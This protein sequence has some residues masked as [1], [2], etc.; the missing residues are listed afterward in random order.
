M[1]SHHAGRRPTGLEADLSRED[2]NEPVREGDLPGEGL[3]RLWAIEDQLLVWK[4][5][6]KEWYQ[7][8]Y[9]SLRPHLPLIVEAMRKRWVRRLVEMLARDG[10]QEP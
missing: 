9:G 4:L 6:A 10:A 3:R 2:A 8:Q 1:K 5:A 7:S